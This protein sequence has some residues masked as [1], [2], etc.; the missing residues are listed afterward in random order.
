MKEKDFYSPEFIERL[1]KDEAMFDELQAVQD[2]YDI[3]EYMTLNLICDSDGYSRFHTKRW[4]L[5][6]E[7]AQCQKVIP[8]SQE[9]I[10]RFWQGNNYD[11]IR[12][13]AKDNHES[14]KAAQEE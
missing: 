7:C 8:F 13:S 3:M 10:D 12:R 2:E 6:R 14:F 5:G 1:H 4:W 11:D 9:K